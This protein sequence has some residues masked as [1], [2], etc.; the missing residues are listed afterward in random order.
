M[1]MPVLGGVLADTP[2]SDWECRPFAYETYSRLETFEDSRRA[3]IYLARSPDGCR[4]SVNYQ[5][6]DMSGWHGKCVFRDYESML[7]FNARG[8]QHWH[9]TFCKRVG[10]V[11]LGYAHAGRAMRLA[12]LDELWKLHLDQWHVVSKAEI[13]NVERET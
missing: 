13:D 9:A 6:S 1:K 10:D 2:T 8:T 5:S 3:V 12:P 7:T 11:Y 4:S